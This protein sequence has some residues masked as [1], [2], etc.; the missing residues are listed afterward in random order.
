MKRVSI[1]G[2]IGNEV[3][4]GTK[5]I[6]NAAVVNAVAERLPAEEQ[7]QCHQ[8]I[9]DL[10]NLVNPT[11]GRILSQFNTS[12]GEFYDLFHIIKE[13]DEGRQK[14]CS[15]AISQ[16]NDEFQ[17]KIAQLRDALGNE[18]FLQAGKALYEISCEGRFSAKL[19]TG[20]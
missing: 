5:Y 14:A 7:A 13:E 15:E 16:L 1:A 2:A 19:L 10:K 8:F 12:K 4:I 20:H 3:P 6:K 18:A 9:A 17:E 11:G